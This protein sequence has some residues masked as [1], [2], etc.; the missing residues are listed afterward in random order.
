MVKLSVDDKYL[1]TEVCDTGL[2]IKADDLNKLF[3]FFG[4]L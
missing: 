1:I 3:T 2:G 4:K